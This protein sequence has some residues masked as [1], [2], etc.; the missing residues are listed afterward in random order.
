MPLIGRYR[1][2]LGRQFLDVDQQVV[3]AGAGELDARGR[4]AHALEAELDD[5][6]AADFGSVG[7]TDNVG[8]PGAGGRKCNESR[9]YENALR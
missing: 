1:L 7:G 9:R 5:E 3:M 2:A 6:G 4:D 8:L